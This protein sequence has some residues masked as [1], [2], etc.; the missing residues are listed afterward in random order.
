MPVLLFQSLNY[1]PKLVKVINLFC[2]LL[3]ASIVFSFPKGSFAQTVPEFVPTFQSVGIYWGPSGGSDGNACLVRY[4]RQGSSIYHEALPLWYDS[5]DSQYRGSIVNLQPETTYEVELELNDGTTSTRTFSTWSE[6]FPVAEIHYID[7]QNSPLSIT[8]GGT[9]NGYILYTPPAGQSATI[10]VNNSADAC[11]TISAPYVIV[12]GFNLRGALI[13]GIQISP[14][15]HDVVIEENDISN[16]GRVNSGFNSP[17]GKDLDAGI[18][19]TERWSTSNLNINRLIIQRNK[20]HHPR[21]TANSWCQWSGSC[22]HPQGPQAITFCRSGG[23]FVIRYNEIYSDDSHYFNDCMGGGENKSENGFPTKD[24]DIYGN[25]IS[26]CRDDAIEAEGGDINVRIWGNY[27]DQ[28]YNVMGLMVAQ[29]GPV[30]IWR[31]V[32]ARSLLSPRNNDY[33]DNNCCT[34]YG[35]GTNT[36]NRGDFTKAGITSGWGGG[37][38]YLYHNT[39][40]QPSPSGGMSYPLG[41]T[42][43]IDTYTELT[44]YV[45]RNN[46]AQVF[47]SN[48]ESVDDGGSN[49][50]NLDYDLCN[51]TIKVDGN[52]ETH[53]IQGTPTYANSN[54]A[55][56]F[57]LSTSSPGYNHGVRIPNF[58]DDYSGSAPDMGAFETG[59]IALEFGVD[60]YRG[61]YETPTP[62]QKEKGDADCNGLINLND[63]VIWLSAYKKI[64]NNLPITEEEKSEVDFDNNQAVNLTDFVIWL[65]SFRQTL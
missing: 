32:S 36:P 57:F 53:A 23:N 6:N 1:Y 13:N 11:I 30:Y 34:K 42:G 12:R 15:A 41:V 21:Y 60:A 43:G 4:R 24:T 63:F 5:R 8:S 58:N 7:S 44:N 56:E 65:V 55:Y 38:V 10:D 49:T 51:G 9:S 22:T 40:L 18:S 29:I 52:E 37:R 47:R 3:I 62:C 59:Q 28:T 26:Y 35:W 50:S 64:L 2:L 19:Y 33:L 45:S 48:E 20:I 61:I 39:M 25:I 31:N 27:I 14:G 46:I 54:G 17:Y 16:W